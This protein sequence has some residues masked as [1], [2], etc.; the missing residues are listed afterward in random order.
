[1]ESPKRTVV[2]AAGC[3]LLLAPMLAS[4]SGDP[5][6]GTAPAPSRAAPSDSERSTASGA[7]RRERS[8]P[9]DVAA[10]L[11]P[12]LEGAATPPRSPREAASQ[13]EAADSAIHDRT[14]TPE[15]LAAAGHTQ[16]VAYRELGTRPGWDERVAALLPRALRRD[17]ATNVAARREF[18][19]MAPTARADLATELPAWRIVRPRPAAELRSYYR[20]AERRYGVD[21]EYLAAINLVETGFGRI[22]GVSSAG[23]RGP[24]QFIPTTW[25]IYGRGGDIE[26]PRDA[27]LAAGRLLRA[28]GFARDKAGSLD[29]YN[30][31]SAYVRGV[32]LYAEV[33]QRR[34]RTYLAYHQ[35]PIYYLT[36]AGSVWLPEGYSE[37]RPVPVKLWLQRQRGR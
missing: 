20:D 19:S 12:A 21:W 4:C 8:V 36:R 23:A 37:R 28:N 27:I 10:A 35:W 1:M 29:N 7:E 18:R 6:G 3:A 2:A 13:I 24:M 15:L 32:T 34:P 16:Q 5:E 33:M 26:D 31:S 11:A 9:D 14:T 30:N 22:D 25:D 17:T